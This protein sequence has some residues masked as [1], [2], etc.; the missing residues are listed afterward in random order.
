[1]GPKEEMVARMGT[2][3]SPPPRV[4]NSVGNDAGAHS[5]PTPWVLAASFS[6]GSPA[7]AR[8]ERSPFMSARK[9]GTPASES[10][11]AMSWRVLVLPVPV[12]PAI[13]PC[14]FIM[15]IG[16]AT[17]ASGWGWPS[18]IAAPRLTAGPSNR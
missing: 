14:R 10:C 13:S 17:R 1:M 12:A 18:D 15:E 5:C 8:P 4:K 6:L 7:A 16:R 3:A 9:T 2:P 11:S